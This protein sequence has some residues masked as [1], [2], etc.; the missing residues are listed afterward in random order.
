VST[1]TP[2]LIGE[3]TG[4][5]KRPSPNPPGGRGSKKKKK[6]GEQQH[7]ST[8]AEELLQWGE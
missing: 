5:G 7:M 4:T 8:M 3:T 2:K 6:A 1:T